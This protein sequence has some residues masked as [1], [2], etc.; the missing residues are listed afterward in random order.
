MRPLKDRCVVLGITGGIAAYKAADLV[1]RLKKMGADV[2]VIMTR[3]AAEFI[4]PLTLQSLSQNP[5]A[6]DMFE[7]PRSWEIRHISLAQSADVFVIA[8][9]TANVIGKIAGGLAD[10][11]LTTTVM[12]TKAPVLIAPAMNTNMYENPIVQQ[13]IQKLTS[14][15][16]TFIAPESG[17]LACGDIGRGKLA[18]PAHI[19]EYVQIAALR[20]SGDLRGRRI[21]VTAGAT[22][23]ALDPVR[24]LTNHSS[25]KMGYAVANAAYLRGAD[26]VLVSAPSQQAALPGVTVLPVVS[27]REMYAA[28]MEQ[29]PDADA[30]IKAAAVAD[31]RPAE[32][33][34]QKLKK[35]GIA[36]M[37][38]QLTANPDILQELGDLFGGK[39]VIAGFCM[40]T[41]D[42]LARAKEKLA[43]KGADFIVANDLTTAG[44]GFGT[45]TNVVTILSAD[46]SAD[47]LPLMEKDAVANELLDRIA[48]KL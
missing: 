38:L 23:E 45:D 16:Y 29:A 31:F 15:G 27:A 36:S 5:V 48:A 14:L 39:K 9:C 37:E 47:S 1:S 19:A 21:L 8:P 43:R 25:G 26:V 44:A 22:Q 3:S 42:L 10:D 20:P 24:Y 4:A 30:V 12:A 18:D 28:V 11:L 41:Q 13:N 46:G 33:A 17:R 2:K 34:G 35:S 7:E 6:M 40:E 32:Q